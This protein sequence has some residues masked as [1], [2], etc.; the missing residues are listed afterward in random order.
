[1]EVRFEEEM[2]CAIFQ[3]SRDLSAKQGKYVDMK[4]E[5]E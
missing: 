3:H 5:P 4:L 1:M 2:V